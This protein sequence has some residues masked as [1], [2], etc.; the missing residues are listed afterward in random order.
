MENLARKI[1]ADAT[2]FVI[3]EYARAAAEA[4]FDIARVRQTKVALIERMVAF[5]QL[6]QLQFFKS[7]RQVTAFFNAWDHGELKLPSPS[8]PQGRCHQQKRIV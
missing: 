6:E 4:E 5:G 8:M 2:D 1:A 7:V 3:L